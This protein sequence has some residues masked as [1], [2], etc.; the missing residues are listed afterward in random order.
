M[1][2]KFWIIFIISTLLSFILLFTSIYLWV[3]SK[4]DREKQDLIEI[5]N[6]KIDILVS[7]N[8][9]CGS[10]IPYMQSADYKCISEKNNKCVLEKY[11]K[12]KLKKIIQDMEEAISACIK[13]QPL[14]NNQP[15]QK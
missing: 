7:V 8:E 12:E 14:I 4:V 6:Q 5:V 2:R 13:L 10:Y 1:H 9:M 11:K 3:S 15:V